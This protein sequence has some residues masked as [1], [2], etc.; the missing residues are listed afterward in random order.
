MV[1]HRHEWV[2]VST[3]DG[4]RRLVWDRSPEGRCVGTRHTPGRVAA[5]RLDRRGVYRRLRRAVVL[6]ADPDAATRLESS[7]D[8][9]GWL[10][11]SPVVDPASFDGLVELYRR[12]SG[13]VAADRWWLH[14][15]GR[16]RAQAGGHL[17]R[18]VDVPASAIESE[19]RVLFPDDPGAWMVDH[20]V[21]YR[22]EVEVLW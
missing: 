15:L 19:G 14:T 1:A 21:A 18:P 10:V 7:G 20:V 17:V 2:P 16:G 8:P 12:V 5:A 4:D 3:S 6:A 22:R 11:L 9:E 13:V